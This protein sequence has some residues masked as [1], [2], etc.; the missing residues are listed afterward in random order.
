MKKFT[1]KDFIAYN[2]PCFSCGEKINFKFKIEFG[3]EF[4]QQNFL[5]VLVGPNSCL[6]NLRLNYS[7]TLQLEIFH[8]T[9][10]ILT[11]NLP[12][13]KSYLNNNDLYLYN[14]C[15]KCFT[16]IT[17]QRLEFNLDKLFINP[18]ELAREMLVVSNETHMYSLVSSFTDATTTAYVD[19]LDESI[20]VSFVKF[21]LPLL[22]L[23]KI[24][25]REK[26]INK[27]KTYLTFS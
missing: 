17:S 2:S 8:E 21:T 19:L 10:K 25:T 27:I 24:K 14:K 26:L 13:L 20:P 12:E 7:S 4:R 11:N 22:P 3:K 18:V 1:V 6:T 16:T 5:R 15:D 23:Y 9:N